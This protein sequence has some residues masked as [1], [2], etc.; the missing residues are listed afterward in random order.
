MQIESC[1]RPAQG[2]N[3]EKKLRYGIWDRIAV[4]ILRGAEEEMKYKDDLWVPAVYTIEA[5]LII[6][7]SLLLIAGGILLSFEVFRAGAESVRSIAGQ[8]RGRS[9]SEAA[10]RFRLARAA[11]DVIGN[12]RGK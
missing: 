1:I 4:R 9:P 7:I 12:L 10:D 2:L 3:Q 11:A 6:S 8:F 5:S